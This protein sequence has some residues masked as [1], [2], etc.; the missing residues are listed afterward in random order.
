[1]KITLVLMTLL[2][3]NLAAREFC[4]DNPLDHFKRL[5][6][7]RNHILVE[8]S[9]QWDKEQ[10]LDPISKEVNASMSQAQDNQKLMQLMHVMP[11]LWC[12]DER[13][14]LDAA[15]RPG[16]RGMLP[17]GEGDWPGTHIRYRQDYYLNQ[18]TVSKNLNTY[19]V[20]RVQ[21]DGKD[22]ELVMQDKSVFTLKSGDNEPLRLHLDYTKS[23]VLF[24]LPKDFN[25]SSL[26]I[27]VVKL[28]EGLISY[29]PKEGLNVLRDWRL[30]KT[31]LV[32]PLA[33][34]YNAAHKE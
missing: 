30:L 13:K 8:F 34:V 10:L 27:G 29:W 7:T 2:V 21:Q 25:I 9:S 12:C 20:A 18:S 31:P 5:C 23:K 16:S 32:L 4:V 11:S 33:S 24:V 1:M 14:A 22:Y 19:I 17:G 28:P 15:M 3:Q 6:V 26:G